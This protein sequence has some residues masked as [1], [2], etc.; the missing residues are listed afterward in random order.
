MSTWM[1]VEDEPNIYE[2]LMTMF[3]MWGIDG[4]AF[5]DGETAMAW[6]EDVDAGRY[7]GELPE[8]ALL[9]IRLPG[10]ISGPLVGERLRRSPRLKQ[11]AIVLTTAYTMSLMEEIAVIERADADKLVYK[12]LPGFADFRTILETVIAER[13]ARK[14]GP[15]LPPA[16]RI[17][18]AAARPSAYSRFGT[19]RPAYTPPAPTIP[20]KDTDT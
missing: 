10:S 1:V 3:Q 8:L 6:I 4:K 19:G 15:A 9:D 20:R 2:L 5:I 7:K 17:V 12:P 14:G 18:R 13:H 11:I 16:D